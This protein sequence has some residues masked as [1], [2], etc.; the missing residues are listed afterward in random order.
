MPTKNTPELDALTAEVEALKSNLVALGTELNRMKLVFFAVCC[1]QTPGASRAYDL[2]GLTEKQLRDRLASKR[3]FLSS[4]ELSAIER[5]L[6]A[7]RLVFNDF[8]RNTID[9]FNWVLV[10]RQRGLWVPF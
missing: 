10:C 5:G 4:W 7:G 2:C 8:T 3:E 1:S 6:Q 9:E